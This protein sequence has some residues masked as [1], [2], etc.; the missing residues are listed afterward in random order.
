MSIPSLRLHTNAVIEALE[1][2]GLT[3]GDADAE[4]LTA[5]YVVVYPIPGGRFSGTLAEPKE[6]AE[7]VYQVS[8]VGISREQSQWHADKAAE[9]IDGLTITDRLVCRVHPDGGPGTFREDDVD[10]PLFTT[11]IRFRITTTPS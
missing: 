8:A 3:V 2:E 7:L 6:D 10:P 1:A 11:P 5:P 9:L 4:G